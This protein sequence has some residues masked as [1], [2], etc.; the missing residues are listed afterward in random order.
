EIYDDEA[1]RDEMKL[2]AAIEVAS[3]L[4]EEFDRKLLAR[5]LKGY[6]E[7]ASETLASRAQRYIEKTWPGFPTETIRDLELFGLNHALEA[8]ERGARDGSTG[9]LYVFNVP[10]VLT[11]AS[12]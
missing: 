12:V 11:P 7:R 6:D 10:E 9:L 8:H 4:A 3:D 1:E 2:Y 5:I